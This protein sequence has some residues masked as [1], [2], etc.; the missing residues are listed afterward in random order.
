MNAG[1]PIIV[2]MLVLLLLAFNSG[3]RSSHPSPSVVVMANPPADE[4]GT[5]CAPILLA[6][7]I[8]MALLGML[9]QPT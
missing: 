6:M 7:L 9:L 4:S 3:G 5:G 8:S 2:S 1:L